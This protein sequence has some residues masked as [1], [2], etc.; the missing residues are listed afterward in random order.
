MFTT[1]PSHI[2]ID[3]AY[4]IIIIR[5]SKGAACSY[6][7]MRVGAPSYCGLFIDKFPPEDILEQDKTDWFLCAL[8]PVLCVIPI[9][10]DP[11]NRT[12]YLFV[13]INWDYGAGDW[14]MWQMSDWARGCHVNCSWNHLVCAR[15]NE[16]VLAMASLVCLQISSVLRTFG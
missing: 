9:V 11:I 7:S 15:R 12:F 6:I 4:E 10:R 5:L 8:H 13:R 14:E 16:F 1:L 3:Q 2:S